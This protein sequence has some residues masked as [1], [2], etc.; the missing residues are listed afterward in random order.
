MLPKGFFFLGSKPCGERVV[1]GEDSYHSSDMGS[2]PSSVTT[3]MGEPHLQALSLGIQVAVSVV[4]DPSLFPKSLWGHMALL[5]V[6][7]STHFTYKWRR[8]HTTSYFLPQPRREEEE[9]LIRTPAPSVDVKTLN[10][11]FS[12]IT[13]SDL[14]LLPSVLGKSVGG[15]T[16]AEWVWLSV[17]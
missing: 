15:G 6:K 10:L 12:Q 14:Q 5:T 1:I 9:H 3:I 16:P 4:A 7:V 11:S 17:N 8:M 13:W 2:S